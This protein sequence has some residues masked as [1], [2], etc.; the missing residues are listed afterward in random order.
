M[1][2]LSLD[3]QGLGV[4]A[5]CGAPLVHRVKEQA[6][7]T[8]YDVPPLLG[9]GRHLFRVCSSVPAHDVTDLGAFANG[10]IP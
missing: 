5:T 7:S 4:C 10:S 1:S 8:R 2:Q 3:Q 6:G 9:D